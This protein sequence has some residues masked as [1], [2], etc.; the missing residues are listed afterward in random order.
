MLLFAGI[1][2][3]VLIIV[4]SLILISFYPVWHFG[5]K[6][7]QQQRILTLFDASADPRGSGYHIIQSKIAAGS[8]GLFGKGYMQGS[9]TQLEFL[10]EHNT[11]FIFSVLTEEWGFLGAIVLISLYWFLIA[12]LIWLAERLKDPFLVYFCM[13][14]AIFILLEVFVNIAMVLGL[15]PVVGIPLPLF[16][17]GGSSMLVVMFLS[18]IALNISTKRRQLINE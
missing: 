11:D 18:G 10:P 4:A 7:Y 9:Q 6:P 14:F 3:R 17:Y 2:R 15:L 5:M 16:S 8:G 12:R 1:K 13:G